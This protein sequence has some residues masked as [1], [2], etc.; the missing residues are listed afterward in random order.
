MP[1]GAEL[2][3]FLEAGPRAAYAVWAPPLEG[4][5]SLPYA[6]TETGVEMAFNAVVLP[7]PKVLRV[8]PGILA[9]HERNQVKIHGDDFQRVIKVSFGGVRAADWRIVNEH[10]II[11]RTRPTKKEGQV[12][13]RVKTAAGTSPATPASAVRFRDTGHG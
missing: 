5:A 11:A 9:T 10:L 4:G 6:G 2:S 8:G 7:E 3:A 12:H 1:A 13:V